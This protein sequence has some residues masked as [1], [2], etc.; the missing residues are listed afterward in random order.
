MA[1]TRQATKRAKQS[2][3]HRLRNTSQ[4][5]AMRSSIKKVLTLVNATKKEEAK[6]AL[7]DAFSNLDR[8]A[9]HKIIHPNKAA[10]LKSRLS[11]K[12]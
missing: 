11:K 5:S 8:L 7:K 9:A 4:K 10:R 1:N 12:V 3:N 6:A 2:E